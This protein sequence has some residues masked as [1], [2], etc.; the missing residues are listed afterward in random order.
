M[1]IWMKQLKLAE[2]AISEYANDFNSAWISGMRSK[3]GF[4][5]EEEGDYVLAQN[6]FKWMETA[7]ADFTEYL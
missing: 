5:N 3:L 6:L 4:L 2:V 1:K 7:K